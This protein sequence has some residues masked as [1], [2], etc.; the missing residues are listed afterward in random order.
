[1][2]IC[3]WVVALLCLAG[4]GGLGP[5]PAV[6]NAGAGGLVMT[7]SR[8]VMRVGET[9]RLSV[10][11]LPGAR[12]RQEEEPA[13]D[14]PVLGVGG[15]GG[16]SEDEV[17]SDDGATE[18][19]ASADGDGDRPEGGDASGEDDE[20]S[21]GGAGGGEQPPGDGEDGGA[22]GNGDAEA[23]EDS[24][25]D[26][27]AVDQAAVGT[28]YTCPNMFWYTSN[29]R[30]ATVDRQGLVRAVGVGTAEITVRTCAGTVS[31]SVEVR[32]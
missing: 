28:E 1:M 26:G 25:A 32:R 13:E 18:D 19:G 29:N 11:L 24:P 20:P 3:R 4:C 7:P 31:C 5:G 8:L 12:A 9:I 15:E 17:E 27:G 21:L 6:T 10:R 2:R 30:V 22:P 23:L 14:E 16:A